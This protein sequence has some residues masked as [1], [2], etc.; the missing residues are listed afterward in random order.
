MFDNYT[1]D[2]LNNLLN[3]KEYLRENIN[4]IKEQFIKFY[5][6]EFRE[7]V[8]DAFNNAIFIAYKALETDEYITNDIK[9]KKS[10]EIIEKY[11]NPN[12]A[13]KKSKVLEG[14]DIDVEIYLLYKFYT[15]KDEE[16]RKDCFERLKYSIFIFNE[17]IT[18]ENYSNYRSDPVILELE[19]LIENYPRMFYEYNAFIS[20]YNEKIENIKAYNKKKQEAG[21]YNTSTNSPNEIEKIHKNLCESTK[22]FRESREE[23][24]KLELLNKD[25]GFDSSIYGI[26]ELASTNSNLRLINGIYSL[27]SI[28]LVNCSNI[29]GYNKI[30]HYIIHELNHLFESFL[31]HANEKEYVVLCGWDKI[32]H[33]IKSSNENTSSTQEAIEE[34]QSGFRDYELFNEIINDMIAQEIYQQMRKDGIYIFDIPDKNDQYQSAYQKTRFL[35]EEFYK[36]YKDKI[37][38]S[39]RD[40]NIDIIW[41]T[42][43]RENFEALNDLFRNIKSTSDLQR[44]QEKDYKMKLSEILNRMDEYY[45]ES[46]QSSKKYR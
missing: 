20:K 19:E 23:L 8:Y 3:C 11:L 24:D 25:D 46:N 35:V 9:R 29:N 27:F 6:E 5:G 16:I 38:E 44:I 41:N 17:N 21:L 13:L 14:V 43:G 45:K 18:F 40:G 28:I 10:K 37:I 7:K 34:T 33:E 15:E 36:R 4:K 42:V 1:I 2:N 22:E 32:K 31:I 26:S 30:D 39:R 12:G